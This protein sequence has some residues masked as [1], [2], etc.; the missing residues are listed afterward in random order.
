MVSTS[1]APRHA[2]VWAWLPG[3]AEP[4][5]AGQVRQR[6]APAGRSVTTTTSYEFAYSQTYLARPDA[7]SLFLPEVPLKNGWI[8]PPDGM[9]MAGCLRDG[10]PDSWGQRVII[11]RL[12]Q[13]QFILAIMSAAIL[14]WLTDRLLGDAVP[15]R[16]REVVS[17]LV[18][19]IT[20][21]MV[22]P[23][24]QFYFGNTKAS[25]DKT[26]ALSDN[27]ATLRRAG[28]LP[29]A[30]PQPVVIRQPEGDPVPGDPSPRPGD[31]L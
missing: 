20:G 23:G 10:S 2:F 26:K 16:M 24:W 3:S 12:T 1:S 11:D 25:D 7:I 17:V 18:G 21:Q 15:D 30:E 8:D 5:L 22:G 4:V 14:C 13:P 19:F 28:A 27:A 6:R 9:S 31:S 29:A